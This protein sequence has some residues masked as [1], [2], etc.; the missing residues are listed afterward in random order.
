MGTLRIDSSTETEDVTP[1][2]GAPTPSLHS[3]KSHSR[4]RLV[5]SHR[6]GSTRSPG[7]GSGNS[8]PPG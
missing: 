7:A 2:T 8:L 1:N 3:T 6:A 4:L 5:D